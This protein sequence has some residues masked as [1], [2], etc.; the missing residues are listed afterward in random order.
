MDRIR[1]FLISRGEFF[2]HGGFPLNFD[3]II[4]FFIVSFFLGGASSFSP[5]SCFAREKLPFA[6]INVSSGRPFSN[7]PDGYFWAINFLKSWETSFNDRR[8]LSHG[9]LIQ[10][11]GAKYERGR[12]FFT[13]R[14]RDAALIDAARTE[15]A[16]EI[17]LPR[18]CF[19]MRL[20]RRF[21]AV[22]VARIIHQVQRFPLSPGWRESTPAIEEKQTWN[23]H[24][25][26]AIHIVRK[27]MDHGTTES[28]KKEP[29]FVNI[30]APVRHY[31][32]SVVETFLPTAVGNNWYRG[33]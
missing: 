25:Q 14:I 1:F 10:Y 20:A 16:F 7:P 31:P 11:L 22:R 15:G 13:A 9:R 8:F 32:L 23:F 17:L 2:R 27:L 21:W 4:P 19:R 12:E 18:C 5:K 6:S 29:K 28:R 30:W 24:Y 26:D 33:G 3:G